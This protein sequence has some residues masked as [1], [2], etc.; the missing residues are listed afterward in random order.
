MIVGYFGC[1]VG[2]W[3]G[4]KRRH[5]HEMAGQPDNFFRAVAHHRDRHE[6]P[7]DRTP[8][9]GPPAVR[10]GEGFLGEG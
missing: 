9:I 7:L 8:F 4:E 10:A 3:A 5:N 1:D 2:D 6:D